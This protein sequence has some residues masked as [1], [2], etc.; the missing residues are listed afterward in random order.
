MCVAVLP[1]RPLDYMTDSLDD[2]GVGHGGMGNDSGVQAWHGDHLGVGGDEGG[3]VGG[4]G[5]CLGGKR[6]RLNV[7]LR[8]FVLDGDVL[9][10]EGGGRH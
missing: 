6:L 8:G 10:D 1:S 9:R 7:A 4:G 5:R 2:R 3:G